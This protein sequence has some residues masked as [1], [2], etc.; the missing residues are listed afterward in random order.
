MREGGAKNPDENAQEELTLKPTPFPLWNLSMA[1][2][3]SNSEI[4][5]VFV[6]DE[7]TALPHHNYAM[8]PSPYS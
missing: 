6:T 3:D 7:S 2:D 8:P 4:N 5:V 1:V